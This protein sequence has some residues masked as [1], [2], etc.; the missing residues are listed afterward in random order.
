MYHDLIKIRTIFIGR[1]GLSHLREYLCA[2]SDRDPQTE[3]EGLLKLLFSKSFVLRDNK[4]AFGPLSSFK[5]VD[6]SSLE[7]DEKS[8]AKEVKNQP[9]TTVLL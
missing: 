3:S 1:D 8:Q 2:L 7:D 6:D 9:V 5:I 4:F